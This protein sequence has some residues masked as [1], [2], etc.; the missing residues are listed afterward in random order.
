MD[1]GSSHVVYD[2]QPPSE[3][4][5][6][7][8]TRT[9]TNLFKGYLILLEDLG[10]S[11]DEALAKLKAALPE[12]YRGYV[13]LADYLTEERGTLLRK[14]VL[15]GGNDVIREVTKLL[16]QFDVEFKR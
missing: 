14:K 5:R 10:D 1:K 11:H 12:P 3:I 6:F 7:Q 4:L 8:L 16:E 2:A 13:D 9:I 15:D